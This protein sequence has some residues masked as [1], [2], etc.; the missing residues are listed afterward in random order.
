MNGVERI[1]V[2]ASEI[3]D[4]ALLKII[5]YLINRTDMNEKYLNEEKSLKQ[6]VQYIKDRAKAQAQNGMAMIE[7]EV[8]YGWAIHYFDEPNSVLNLSNN[9]KSE[10]SLKSI[11]MPREKKEYVPEG[12]LSLFGE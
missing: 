3:R 5:D 12:Q 2:L 8:V 4:K 11:T 6:M 1:K 7:D 10:S 9:T